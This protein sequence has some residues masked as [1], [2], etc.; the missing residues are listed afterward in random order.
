MPLGNFGHYIIALL[1]LCMIMNGIMR[2]RSLYCIYVSRFRQSLNFDGLGSDA[3]LSESLRA[4]ALCLNLCN[5]ITFG[6]FPLS[7]TLVLHCSLLS[8]D[9]CAVFAILVISAKDAVAPSERG[10]KIV[11]KG[12][13]VEVMMLS[14]R[15]EGD[16]VLQ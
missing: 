4:L 3:A 14:A 10:G 7:L 1:V 5:E 6:H 8:S 9:T 12:H 15:P 16:D 2:K 13:V 11:R